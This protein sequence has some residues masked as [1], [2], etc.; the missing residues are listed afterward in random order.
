MEVEGEME[1]KV[2]AATAA[3]LNPESVQKEE[4]LEELPKAEEMGKP[5]EV[6][7]AAAEMGLEEILKVAGKGW[8]E[9]ESQKSFGLI[10]EMI[11]MEM[12]ILEE[13][14]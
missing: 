1:R 9:M 2:A 11:L 12:E 8:E 10:I 5:E 7:K 6:L 14:A 3:A 4:K 13:G